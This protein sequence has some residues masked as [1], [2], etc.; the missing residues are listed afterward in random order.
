MDREK[1]IPTYFST[2]ILLC[3]SVLLFIIFLFRR[4]QRD[5][6][7][8]Y[9]GGLAI[10]F[11]ILSLDE[12]VG[13]HELTVDPVK[14]TLNLSGFLSFGWV[15]PAFFVLII[16]GVAFFKFVISLDTR[17]RYWFIISGALYLSGALG[18]ELIGGYL[19]ETSGSGTFIYA[20]CTNIEETLEMLGISFF[21]YTL[22][23]YIQII[24]PNG[25]HFW[26]KGKKI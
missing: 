15:V 13:F 5:K 3:C 26:V 25:I 14:E 16:F 24:K 11:L 8:G 12:F 17:I 18:M 19:M 7:Y 23:K 6:E 1:N 4:K 9:W 21:I 22:L 20:L 2:L 10:I